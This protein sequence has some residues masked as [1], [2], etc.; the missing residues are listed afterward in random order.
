MGKA[1]HKPRAVKPEKKEAQSNKGSAS[2][3]WKPW[4]LSDYGLRVQTVKAD[5]NCFFRAVADQIEVHALT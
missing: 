4:S 2:S 1:K 5:G 3:G